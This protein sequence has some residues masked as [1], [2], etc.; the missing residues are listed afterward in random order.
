MGL[1]HTYCEYSLLICTPHIRRI[2][3]LAYIYIYIYNR[4]SQYTDMHKKCTAYR[5]LM[6]TSSPVITQ[7]QTSVFMARVWE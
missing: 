6:H 1:M 5:S 7:A 2:V 4:L 3:S